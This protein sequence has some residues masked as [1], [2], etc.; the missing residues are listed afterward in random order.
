MTHSQPISPFA[1]AVSINFPGW[2]LRSLQDSSVSYLVPGS[3][4]RPGTHQATNSVSHSPQ[5]TYVLEVD[6]SW[7]LGYAGP[8]PDSS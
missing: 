5:G 8:Y 7:S 4:P 1:E 3:M 2:S 6:P